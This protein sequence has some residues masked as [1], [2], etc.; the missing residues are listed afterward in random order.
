MPK[1]GR[2]TR[3][4]GL[5]KLGE[6]PD[7]W[8]AVR[9]RR[10]S[11]S[12]RYQKTERPSIA[13]KTV[14]PLSGLL[15]CGKCSAPMTIFGGSRTA[16]R[17]RCS[18]QIRRGTCDNTLSVQETVAR[19]CIIG[20]VKGRLLRPEGLAFIREELVKQLGDI[21]RSLD[22][23]LKSRRNRLART[24]DKIRGLIEF[25]AGGDQSE[26]IVQTLHDLEAH[27]K[28]EKAVIAALVHQARQPIPL[29][30]LDELTTS[31]CDLESRLDTDPI[32]DRQALHQLFRDG[33]LWDSI[34]N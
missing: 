14:Y 20:A 3:H 7:L 28:E 15:Y 26:Y 27:A 2:V 34:P 31:V 10:A 5:S 4:N 30:S 18:H 24:E 29:P 21:N 11:V 22:E 33:R 32:G 6:C 16:K 25:I 8:N 19:H 9:Q 1:Y 17:Y 12:S 13:S 23:D